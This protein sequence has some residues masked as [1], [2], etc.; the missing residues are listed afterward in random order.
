MENAAISPI[1]RGSANKNSTNAIGH[2]RQVLV[3][4]DNALN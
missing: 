2:K 1:M 3:R 4:I